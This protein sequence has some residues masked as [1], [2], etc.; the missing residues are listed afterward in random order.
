MQLTRQSEYAIRTLLELCKY[1]DREFVQS[2]SIASQQGLPVQ[3]LNKTVQILARAGLIETRRGMQ[4][5]VRLAVK[6]ETITI[7]DVVAAVEGQVAIN[8]CLTG[9]YTCANQSACRVHGILKRAQ[10][11][12]LAELSRETFADLI[13]EEGGEGGGLQYHF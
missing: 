11:A 13:K 1:P 2:R 3:F 9:S 10:E 5:G 8:P 12:L 7:A 4:G 6:P